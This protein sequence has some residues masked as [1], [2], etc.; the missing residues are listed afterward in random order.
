MK[1]STTISTAALLLMTA[2]VYTL[3]SDPLKIVH[4]DV[5]KGDATL[6]IS[7]SGE[8]L[9]VDAGSEV[10]EPD[11]TAALINAYL[12]EQGIDTIKYTLATHFHDDHINAFL[13]LF[14][15]YGYAP[16][17]AYDRG[18]PG[19]DPTWYNCAAYWRYMNY[20][21]TTSIRD[22]ISAGDIIDLGSG[23]TIKTI[24][25]NG[26]FM[27]GRYD[28]MNIRHQFENVR[29]A[30]LLLEYQNFSYVVAG[31]LTGSGGA[32]GDKETPAAGLIGDIDVFQVNHHGGGSSTNENWLDVLR[33][34]AAVVSANAGMV[35]Q[36]VV[37][38]IDSCATMVTLYHTEFSNVQ[39]IKSRIVDGNV[40]LETDGLTY[41][42]IEDDSFSIADNPQVSLVAI[43]DPIYVSVPSSG[44]DFDFEINLTNNSGDTITADYWTLWHGQGKWRNALGPEQATL[45]AG[46]SIFYELS[47]TMLATYPAGNYIYEARI[48]QYPDN[49]WDTYCFPVWKDTTANGYAGTDSDLKIPCLSDITLSTAS[50]EPEVAVIT[51]YPDPFNPVTVICYR[52]SAGSNVSLAVYDVSGRLV[53]RLIDGWRDAGVHE[54]MFDGSDLVSG[55]YLYRMKAGEYE[56]LGKMILVK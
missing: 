33:P 38:R 17:T 18:S 5:S 23:V 32:H 4:F 36:A 12:V 51:A 20:V 31:D 40:I 41:Y 7:P 43:P 11:S 27:N 52:L 8:T 56:A 55:I 45:D 26:S 29:S 46:A 6:I 39:G 25:S 14:Q 3:K 22:S 42:T 15:S 19:I 30:C 44:G 9:L 50:S 21:E 34:E 1:R 28:P 16:Q 2:C 24:Y 37:D 53:A 10:L 49:I 35:N 47:E 13:K 54:V 48:G